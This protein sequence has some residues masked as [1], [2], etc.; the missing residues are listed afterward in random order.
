MDLFC[1]GKN[2][3][4]ECLGFGVDTNSLKLVYTH[5]GFISTQYNVIYN[6]IEDQST[7]LDFIPKIV[8]S[9]VR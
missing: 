6:G 5:I 1:I 2:F 4:R 3:E 7:C 8:V 9:I